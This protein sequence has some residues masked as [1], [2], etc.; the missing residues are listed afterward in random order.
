MKPEKTQVYAIVAP[1][2]AA[3]NTFIPDMPVQLFPLLV[4][5]AAQACLEL[6]KKDDSVTLN[7]RA[8]AMR[9]LMK[10]RQ[11]KHDGKTKKGFGRR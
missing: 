7:R 10:T 4:N 2:W 6:R 11:I 9:N 1:S 8:T 5:E 3:N